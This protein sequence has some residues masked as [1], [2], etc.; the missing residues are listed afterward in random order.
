MY[1]NENKVI[2]IIY[3]KL[4]AKITHNFNDVT[5]IISF[6]IICYLAIYGYKQ[7]ISKMKIS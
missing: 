1:L 3:V 4:N 6:G 5:S 7:V 2:V